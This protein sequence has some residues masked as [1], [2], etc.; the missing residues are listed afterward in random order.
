MKINRRQLIVPLFLCVL[1]NVLYRAFS[2]DNVGYTAREMLF[3]SF[4]AAIA[5][6]IGVATV[7]LFA[8]VFAR[9]EENKIWKNVVLLL[10]AILLFVAAG[11]TILWQVQ[12]YYRQFQTGVVWVVFFALL[13]CGVHVT[14]SAFSAC[15]RLILWFCAIAAALLVLGLAEQASFQNLSVMPLRE[16]GIKAAF[17]ASFFSYPEYLA[18][19][20]CVPDTKLQGAKQWL[21]F[22]CI[23]FFAAAVQGLIILY[24]ELIFAS[25]MA[26]ASGF[27]FLRSW[28]FLSFSRFDGVVVLLWMMLSY[29]RLRWLFFFACQANPL[30]KQMKRKQ[31][32]EKS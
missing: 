22:L 24:G 19:L 1:C 23:P 16:Q 13:L 8:P 5:V 14:P 17:W 30:Q 3:G 29:F 27:E 31:E 15:A 7:L 25:Q 26:E 10:I 20:F 12:C 4:C 32:G 6:V 2:Q 11:Q 21:P 18:L 28:A 9:Q